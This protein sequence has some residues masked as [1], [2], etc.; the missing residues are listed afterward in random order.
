MRYFKKHLP[1]SSL[2]PNG[3]A[4][5]LNFVDADGIGHLACEVGYVNGQIDSA[6]Q[7]GI[8][9]WENSDE[10][11]YNAAM[12]KKKVFQPSSKKTRWF[13]AD[14]SLARKVAGG[15]RKAVEIPVSPR[16]EPLRVPTP[17]EMKPRKGLMPREAVV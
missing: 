17:E 4:I 1:N 5:V 13:R 15:A 9:G 6:I 12:L 16:P 2:L 3:K 14:P 10:A 11:T 7:Q 8:G